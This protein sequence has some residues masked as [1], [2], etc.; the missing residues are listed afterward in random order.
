MYDQFHT[1]KMFTN[2]ETESKPQQRWRMIDDSRPVTNHSSMLFVCYDVIGILASTNHAGIWLHLTIRMK[3]FSDAQAISMASPNQNQWLTTIFYINS[4]DISTVQYG[5]CHC[6]DS[7][8]SLA[9]PKQRLFLNLTGYVSI[10][11]KYR[12]SCAPAELFS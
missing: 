4:C 5:C 10:V 2:L 1:H 8:F 6:F 12:A 7:T 11:Q 3:W 9:T